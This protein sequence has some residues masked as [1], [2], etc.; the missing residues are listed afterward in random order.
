MADDDL[1]TPRATALLRLLHHELDGERRALLERRQGVRTLLDA[2]ELLDFPDSQARRDP[3]WRVP[4]AP[5]ALQDRRVEI[6][7]PTTPKMVINALNS[8]ARCFMA[9][10]ED[11]NSPTWQNMT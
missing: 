7:G 10:F 8:G 4:P 6:T 11:A 9:D 1:F 2:G 5:P 3:S